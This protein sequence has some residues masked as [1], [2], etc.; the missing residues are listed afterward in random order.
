MTLP[1]FDG[2]IAIECYTR[3]TSSATP[4]DTVLGTLRDYEQR[5]LI[6]DLTVET[7]PDSVVLTGDTKGTADIARYRRFKAWAYQEGVSLDPAFTICKRTTL[8][9]NQA[10]VVLSFPVLCLAVFVG[11]EME[12]VAPHR[13]NTMTYTVTDV[14]AD[15]GQLDGGPQ[16]APN[17]A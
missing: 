1:Q 15:L 10:E 13:T 14:L 11:E 5:E 8:V 16:P 6:D 7:W 3:A 2:P 9:T 17:G 4:V 12:T